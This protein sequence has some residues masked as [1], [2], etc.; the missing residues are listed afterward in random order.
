MQCHF[1]AEAAEIYISFSII[2]SIPNKNNE[3][4]SYYY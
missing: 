4:L 3:I 1:E 2:G